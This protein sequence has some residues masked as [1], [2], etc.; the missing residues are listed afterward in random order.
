V[1][2]SHLNALGLSSA[3]R[4]IFAWLLTLTGIGVGKASA[5]EAPTLKIE[6][7]ARDLP[8]RLLHTRIEVPCRPGKVAF[9]IPKWVPGAHGP[10]GPLQKVE[11]LRVE[12]SAGILVRWYRDESD[13]FHFECN[14]PV[15]VTEIAVRLDTICDEPSHLSSGYFSYGNNSLGIVNWGTCLVY[16]EGFSC[17]DIK[18]QL[19]LRLPSAW[20]YAT[21]LKT[22]Q[23][24]D[25]RISFETLSLAD[26]VD[27]PL[28]A[29]VHLRT[30][31]LDSGDDP[32]AYLHLASESESALNLG[33][34]VVDRYSNVVKEAG[35][36]FGAC[37]YE[38]YHFLVTCSND[39]G[40]FAL[41]HLS[42]S[43][44]GVREREFVEDTG[45]RGWAASLL[46][47]EYVHS[48]CGKFRRP[49]GM[50]TPDF[51][52]PQRT[53]LLWVYEGLA[54]YLGYVL[55][56]RSGLLSQGEFVDVLNTTIRRLFYQAGRRWRSLEDTGVSSY[57]LRKPSPNWNTL[58]RGQDY[59]DEG[60]LLWLE[61]DAIIRERSNG[62]KSL[63]DFCHK[64]LG[65]N[66][67]TTNVIPYE[68]RE[69]VATLEELTHFDWRTFLER[70]VAQLQEKLPLDV[71]QRC[72]YV[73]QDLGQRFVSP[74]TRESYG[75]YIWAAVQDS[76]GLT[77][78]TNGIISDIVPG[79]SSDRAG[80][81]VGMKVIGIN[82][83]TFSRE[84]LIDAMVDSIK[85]HKIELLL[86]EDE[87][88]RTVAIDYSDGI[89]YFVLARD[90]SKPDI[91]SR[92]LN[93]LTPTPKGT[94]APSEIEPR[95]AAVIDVATIDRG[96]LFAG[97]LGLVIIFVVVGLIK[98]KRKWERA[99]S[100]GHRG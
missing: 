76:I 70:R 75:P 39:L 10:L 83:K 71:I 37:H 26:L 73:F 32:P 62:K 16:P 38:E 66:T 49:A 90:E 84:R 24:K 46:P 47:H 31:A 93:P 55:A 7:D 19:A 94:A 12:T 15:G 23:S 6:V 30:I 27:C 64:F 95:R 65:A 48:W 61:A 91:L 60:M 72:G 82:N 36:I 87:T 3:W 98:V 97:V 50:C 56:V 28:I 13:P 11:G 33:S 88:L 77:L 67:S 52:T 17:D 59:Y 78:A 43:V 54:E 92:I 79:T 69:I 14:V 5:G 35:A 68:L 22:N 45:R 41:E 9:W 21:A 51:H 85:R 8:R 96:Q 44:N 99:R 74:A 89:H 1:L 86:I 58:R 57:L 20:R 81:A 4:I 25:G 80:L 42:S 18:V 40:Y 63:D 34:P 100:V 29:G 2:L 53:R